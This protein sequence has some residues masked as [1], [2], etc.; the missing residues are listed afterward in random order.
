MDFERFRQKRPILNDA[1]ACLFYTAHSILSDC[2]ILIYTGKN[3]KFFFAYCFALIN[4][5]AVLG[6]YN[7]TCFLLLASFLFYSKKKFININS[8]KTLGL[9]TLIY[10]YTHLY[11]TGT[12]VGLKFNSR[13]C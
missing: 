6:S 12:R 9:C 4:L 2:V 7:I 5:I 11:I 10:I 3:T 1:D 8:I 13:F